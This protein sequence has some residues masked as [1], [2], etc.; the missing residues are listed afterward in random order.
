MV[1]GVSLRKSLATFLGNLA[2]QGILQRRREVQSIGYGDETGFDYAGRTN[3]D[4]Q[5][6]VASS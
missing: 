3:D 6:L 4:H 5:Q 1:Q 2:D